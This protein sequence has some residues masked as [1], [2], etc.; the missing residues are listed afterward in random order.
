MTVEELDFIHLDTNVGSLLSLL[1]TSRRLRKP[2]PALQA[3]L[4]DRPVG[5]QEA[6]D[7]GPV[8]CFCQDAVVSHADLAAGTLPSQGAVIAKSR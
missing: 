6:Q 3:V 7:T 2:R 8:A 4:K 1:A 5:F